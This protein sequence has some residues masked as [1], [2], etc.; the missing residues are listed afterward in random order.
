MSKQSITKTIHSLTASRSASLTA[1]QKALPLIASTS[2]RNYVTPSQPAALATTLDIDIP[3]KRSS[4]E[5]LV[6]TPSTGN[7]TFELSEGEGKMEDV[8]RPI[9]LDAQATTPVD[10]RVLDAMLPFMTNQYGNPHS[11]THA[12]GWESEK[13]AEVAREVQ[14][15]SC[16]LIKSVLMYTCDCSKSQN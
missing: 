14:P 7:S 11:R 9:Y 5:P 4:D 8:G 15:S 1:P 16:R 6:L 10:P 2:R 12:Y 3:Q 13:A